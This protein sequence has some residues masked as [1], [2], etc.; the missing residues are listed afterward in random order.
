MVA[1]HLAELDAIL[2]KI[3]EPIWGYLETIEDGRKIP[4]G[5]ISE[6]WHV[7][8]DEHAV[9]SARPRVLEH[10]M[11][12][13]S[14][15][16]RG[17][18]ACEPNVY[19]Q[20]RDKTVNI[21]VNG[22]WI[23]ANEFPPIRRVRP[24]ATFRAGDVAFVYRDVPQHAK[25]Y[26]LMPSNKKRNSRRQGAQ[27]IAS[28]GQ[29]NIVLAMRTIDDLS[30]AVAVKYISYAVVDV[31]RVARQ[32]CTW[33]KLRHKNVLP[34]L[35]WHL[36]HREVE[37][38]IC[39]VTP[40]APYGSL[41]D[42]VKHHGK[43]P[44]NLARFIV[45]QVTDGLN[46]MHDQGYVHGD[47]RPQ[48]V[49]VFRERE[50]SVLS[51]Q[52]CD[53]GLTER[54]ETTLVIDKTQFIEFDAHLPGP[55]VIPGTAH[56]AAPELL[57]N[58][59][60]LYSEAF[61]VGGIMFFLLWARPLY[62]I[63]KET[64]SL[65][66]ATQ[67]GQRQLELNQRRLNAMSPPARDLLT[68]LTQESVPDR[69]GLFEARA[70]D[71]LQ[72]IEMPELGPIPLSWWDESVERYRCDE[73]YSANTICAIHGDDDQSDE[74]MQEEDADPVIVQNV[75]SLAVDGIHPANDGDTNVQAPG[76]SGHLTLTRTWSDLGSA[77]VRSNNSSLARTSTVLTDITELEVELYL[78]MQEDTSAPSSPSGTDTQASG[79][80]PHLAPTRTW[81]DVGSAVVRPNNGSLAR[82]STILTD[83]TDM[84]VELYLT[85]EGSEPSSPSGSETPRF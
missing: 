35:S 47:V 21:F 23:H 36:V 79:S 40:F 78:T 46:Y 19:I 6:E 5:L 22:E 64:I 3:R 80:S 11:P 66:F 51:V 52:V 25:R 73:I 17:S 61:G 59:Y 85:M 71:W 42:Y 74:E 4:F 14:I 38:L 82:T 24:D 50:D 48:N 37:K 44:E 53:F 8:C 49:L 15:W 62:R 20:P 56:W 77:A 63:A 28:G 84:E 67:M 30:D 69:I 26:E 70:H 54:F 76:S 45:A 43:Q 13:F 34:F 55:Q 29:G 75:P 83:I 33:Q 57:S 27:V 39:L 16:K 12:L 58:W 1:Q 10:E 72:G 68:K 81:S 9:L 65:P 31:H 18:K 2:Y 32:I 41:Y 60:N 7:F